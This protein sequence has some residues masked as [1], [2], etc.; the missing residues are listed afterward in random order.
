M[1]YL[2]TRVP[3]DTNSENTFIV[4]RCQGVRVVMYEENSHTV[5]GS[6]HIIMLRYPGPLNIRTKYLELVFGHS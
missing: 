2:C 4:G 5:A 6:I 3:Q 1:R